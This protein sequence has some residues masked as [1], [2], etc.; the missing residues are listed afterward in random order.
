VNLCEDRYRFAVAFA[1]AMLARKTSLFPP[2]RHD[3]ALARVAAAYPD[4]GAIAEEPVPVLGDRLARYPADLEGDDWTGAVPVRP[5]TG[6]D[7]FTRSTG[8]PQPN[9]KRWA[10]SSRAACRRAALELPASGFS[11]LGTVP[12]QHMYGFE[13]TVLMALAGG[14]ALHPARPLFPRDVQAALSE[15]PAPR[16]LVTSPIHIR[17][18]VEAA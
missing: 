18:L 6:G 5:I 2:S 16:V 3:A 1:A 9:E 10:T 13:S 14:G 11:V 12:P 17:A 8:V 4:C 7:R 15:L